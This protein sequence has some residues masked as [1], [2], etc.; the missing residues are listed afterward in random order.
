MNQEKLA[1]D[2]S[3]PELEGTIKSYELAFR[4]QGEM[5]KVMDLSQESETT[6]KLYGM[7][8]RKSSNFG[9]KCLMA[10]RFI[11]SGV[12]FVEITHGNWD[13]HFNIDTALPDNCEQIDH[14]IAGLL[15]DLQQRGLLE[16]TLIVCTGEFGRTPYAQAKN[17]RDHNN[18]AFTLWMAGGGVKPGVSYGLRVTSDTKL[19]TSLSPLWTSTLPCWHYWDLIMKNSRIATRAVIFG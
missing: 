17:G 16:S 11:E 7:E 4:M 12:R 3:N 5:P 15:A 19:L 6:K 1:H 18:K 14:G 13:H 2:Q 8:S 9:A 10:R